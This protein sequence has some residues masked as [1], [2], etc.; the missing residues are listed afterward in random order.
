MRATRTDA[1]AFTGIAGGI[2][3]GAESFGLMHLLG[4]RLERLE[5]SEIG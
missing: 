1:L 2:I 5:P 4:G 3:L